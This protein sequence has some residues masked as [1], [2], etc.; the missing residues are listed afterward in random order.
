[1]SH[2]SSLK[3]LKTCN[4]MLGNLKNKYCYQKIIL[5]NLL[6]TFTIVIYKTGYVLKLFRYYTLIL[7]IE[8]LWWLTTK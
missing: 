3:T 2:S 8:Q 5:F 7:W 1:M 6:L 4:Y